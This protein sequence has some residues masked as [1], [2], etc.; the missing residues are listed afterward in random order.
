MS[1]KPKKYKI[2]F[3]RPQL[4]ATQTNELFSYHSKAEVYEAY[5]EFCELFGY[6]KLKVSIMRS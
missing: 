4:N 1:F 2:S 5:K 3:Y 6:T